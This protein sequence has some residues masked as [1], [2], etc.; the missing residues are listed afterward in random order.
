MNTVENVRLS[1]TWHPKSGLLVL[2]VATLAYIS[3]TMQRSSMGVA[4]LEA[5]HRF[6]ASAAELSA[7]AVWQ[8]L[9]YALAQIPVGILLDRIGSRKMLAIGGLVMGIGQAVVA[10]SIHLD[11]AV[12]GRIL[13]GLG[14]AF[15]FTSL[16]RLINGWFEGKIASR[17][18]QWIANTGQVGQVVSAIPFGA[19]LSSSGWTSSFISISAISILFAVISLLLVRDFRGGPTTVGTHRSL[20]GSLSEL[21]VSLH[22]PAVRMAF[23]TH[24]SLQSASAVF[25]LLWGFPFLVQSQGFSTLQA[26]EAMTVVV[27]SGIPFGFI[28]GWI[29]SRWPSSRRP[30]VLLMAGSIVASWSAVLLQAR[31]APLWLI[32]FL[33]VC[34]G[35][36]GSA[37]MVAFD[38]SREHVPLARLGTANGFINVGGF[39]ASLATMFVIGQVLDLAKQL[40]ASDSQPWLL[41]GLPGFRWAF[42]AQICVVLFGVSFFFRESRIVERAKRNI[43]PE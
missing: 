25:V 24:F 37:C 14:D 42:I 18:Q 3:A 32:G 2:L 12:V 35:A 33:L 23:W 20:R 15:I 40:H 43:K 11:T 30:T 5:S 19:F 16:I 8:L 7:L 10:F 39:V 29:F 36:A 26:G 27:L 6:Q 31:P 1:R 4:S 34:L 9:T 38:F 22:E 17:L 21:N 28:Y 13:V 41:Y